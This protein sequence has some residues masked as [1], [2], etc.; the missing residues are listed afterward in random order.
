MIKRILILSAV[1][2]V[3]AVS[4][5]AL[6]SVLKLNQ[7]ATLTVPHEGKY[8]IYT[9]NPATDKVTLIYSTANEIYT[10]TLRLSNHGD[11]FVF[12]QKI[13]GTSDLN[14]EIFTIGVDGTN[15]RRLTNNAYMDLYPAWS[16]DDTQIAFLSNRTKDLDI[17][18]MNADGTNQHLLY[19]SGSHDADIDWASNTIT[20]TSGFK[21]W[22]IEVD[23]TNPTQITNPANAGQWG[24]ANLPIGDY[25]PRL[26]T[27]GSE[28]A[29]ERL[30]DPNTPHGGY[31]IYA[32]NSD[33][34]GE[35][36]LTNTGYAQGLASWSHS[37]DKIIYTVAAIGN[38]GK[39][40]IYMM[41]A[42]GTN[43]SNITPNYFPPSFLC[44]SPIFSTDDSK[45]FFIGQWQP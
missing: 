45:I 37:S 35:T 30:E 10:S 41:N 32:V 40:D 12:A 26:S 22:T 4:A 13:D 34:T 33:G 44:Y 43:N 24:T 9:L 19:D 31:N 36:R 14:T 16:S 18:V 3:I 39:Y 42:D 27:D 29:F 1:L 2:A 6:I 25:D 8:G 11:K 5:I 23:G 15:L 28:I 7:P 20:F 21:I 38:A 17:Y